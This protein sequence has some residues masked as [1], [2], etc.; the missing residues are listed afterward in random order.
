MPYVLPLNLLD[1]EDY[2]LVGTKGANL[3][4]LKKAGLPI[5]SG[6]VVTTEAYRE[7]ISQTSIEGKIGKILD[8]ILPTK[9]EQVI[10]ASQKI[11]K[12]FDSL[13][14][15][16]KLEEEISK[17]AKLLSKENRG[18]LAV[19]SSAI[20]EDIKGLSFAG[21]YVSFLDVSYQK[22]TE[23]IKACW[24]SQFS[25]RAIVY[26]TEHKVDLRKNPIAVIVQDF[27]EAQASGAG[28]TIN[29]LNGDKNEI[30]IEA[31]WGLGLLANYGMVIPDRY[32]VKKDTLRII[33]KASGSQKIQLIHQ[34]NV[35]KEVPISKAFQ[36]RQKLTNAKIIELAKLAK[37][38]E[39]HFY[40][41]Q[42]FEWALKR[43]NLIILQSRP[44]SPHIQ[45]KRAK[46]PFRMPIL[47][48]GTGASKGYG[49]G[50]ARIIKKMGDL[51]NVKRGDV[52]ITAST[53]PNFILGMKK[54]SA[55]V[56]DRGGLT[57][58]AAILARE[59]GKPCVVGAGEATRVLKNGEIVTVEGTSGKIFSG[60]P[61]FP[62]KI[63][64]LK[65]PKVKKSNGRQDKV[66]T[67]HK[68]YCYLTS[69]NEVISPIRQDVDGFYIDEITDGLAR[70]F[71]QAE[72]IFKGRHVIL[73]TKKNN[74]TSLKN[75]DLGNFDIALSDVRS[76][77]EIREVSNKNGN[78]FLV[79]DLP[80]HIFA[81]R[82]FLEEEIKGV[83]I[84]I[85]ELIKNSLGE[86]S[87]DEL[88]VSKYATNSHFTR[89]LENLIGEIKRRRLKMFFL[90]KDQ[91][92]WELLSIAV[93]QG[94]WGVIVPQP[95]IPTVR[96]IL[97]QLEEEVI[98]K[99]ISKPQE[100]T[101]SWQKL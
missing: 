12:L 68:I 7:V 72:K 50:R 41:P 30:I 46:I 96:E 18:N 97:H 49:W 57:S 88:L 32:L 45:T 42:N 61:T 43:D 37:I 59:L 15:P 90:F 67:V 100:R 71:S 39:E 4:E 51:K 93:N 81:Y 91:F 82:D 65:K 56:T 87:E 17:A 44:V 34:D 75:Y 5:P 33:S 28:F 98:K 19:R 99:F 54:A 92:Y 52:L 94:G 63:L 58:H 3:G 73:A 84:D 25:P 8:G 78:I 1:R 2:Q 14:L 79:F 21:E 74:M 55:I 69:L 27:V 62:S 13:P 22:L 20:S 29:P 35:A 40:F 9:P 66:K 83:I 76:R 26:A 80:F 38:I 16:K 85:S 31:I 64:T 86:T 53:N 36:K 47:L 89:E 77:R 11:E 101:A 95:S 6:F 48:S 70:N 23:K 10:E 24:V 60:Q